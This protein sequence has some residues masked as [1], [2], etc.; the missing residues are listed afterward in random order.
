MYYL[1]LGKT[2]DFSSP[3]KLIINYDNN[4]FYRKKQTDW[5]R[6]SDKEISS[7][8][9]GSDNSYY[10]IEKNQFQEILSSWG[11]SRYGYIN[12][13][14]GNCVNDINYGDEDDD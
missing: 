9:S 10:A 13:D 12:F 1:Y 6:L 5:E 3:E 11:G 8:L 4:W 14:L 2:N 7:L